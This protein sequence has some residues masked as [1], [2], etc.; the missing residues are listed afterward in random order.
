MTRNFTRL[1][2][3]LLV[4]VGF[5]QEAL[6]QCPGGYNTAKVNW[7]NLDY[8]YN[9]GANIAPYG[10]NPAGN[11]V[12]NAMQNTMKFAIGVNTVTI[13]MVS[14]ITPNGSNNTNTAQAG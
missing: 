2:L 8:Y 14:N 13:A 3:A 10:F 7:D 4:L 11:F 9:S 1:V 6:A 5:A 12:S